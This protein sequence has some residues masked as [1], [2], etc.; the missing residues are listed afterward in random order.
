MRKTQLKQLRSM[1][2]KI[3]LKNFLKGKKFKVNLRRK[4]KTEREKKKKSRV[5]E[6]IDKLRLWH[7][8]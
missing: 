5:K 2:L 7:K 8:S 3:S 1:S 4:S 6:K